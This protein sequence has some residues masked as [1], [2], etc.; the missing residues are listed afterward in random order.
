MYLIKYITCFQMVLETYQAKDIT[1]KYFIR[2]D[3]VKIALIPPLWTSR[4]S[5]T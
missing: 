2:T 1:N 5:V 4:F 3:E